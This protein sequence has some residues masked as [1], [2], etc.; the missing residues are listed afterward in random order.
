LLAVL[1]SKKIS[2]RRHT[3]RLKKPLAGSTSTRPNSQ[4]NT[5][6]QP[7]SAMPRC[8]CVCSGKA[9]QAAETLVDIARTS[10]VS[11]MTMCRRVL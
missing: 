6:V 3:L 2:P 10:N 7:F 8:K 4:S 9:N 11:P 5:N 1:E